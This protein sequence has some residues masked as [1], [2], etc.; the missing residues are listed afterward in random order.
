VLPTSSKPFTTPEDALGALR[1]SEALKSAILET[2]L[3]CIVTI[4]HTGKVLDFNAAAER[5]F[6]FKRAEVI[7][8]GRWPS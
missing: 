3:D 7:G 4:D 8:P 2:A 1:A 5:T 6:G